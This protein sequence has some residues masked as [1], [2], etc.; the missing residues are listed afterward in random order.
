M[1][2]GNKQRWPKKS[3]RNLELRS[4][5]TVLGPHQ[6]WLGRAGRALPRRGREAGPIDTISPGKE[7]RGEKREERG[8]TGA[9]D[10]RYGTRHW[11]R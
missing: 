2:L 8:E 4:G 5:G 11:M 7:N 10:A 9:N 3:A 1:V 6:P